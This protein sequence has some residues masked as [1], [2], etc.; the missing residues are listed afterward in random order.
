[1]KDA[2]VVV[3][4]GHLAGVPTPFRFK[5]RKEALRKAQRLDHQMGPG[6]CDI[7]AMR[8][9]EYKKSWGPPIEGTVQPRP[10]VYVSTK[11]TS[12]FDEEKK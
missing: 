1:M 4:N 6:T 10:G 3:W 11:S 9:S 5:T 8:E 2:W 12:I 7:R